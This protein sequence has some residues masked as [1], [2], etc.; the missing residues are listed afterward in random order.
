[1]IFNKEELN[2]LELY[3]LLADNKDP[4]K[5]D[6]VQIKAKKDENIVI[7]SQFSEEA[8]LIT[9]LEKKVDEEFT[10]ILPSP[11]LYSLIRTLSDNTILKIEKSGIFFNS[12]KYDFEKVDFELNDTDHFLML[13]EKENDNKK[14]IKQVDKAFLLKPYIGKNEL[15]VIHLNNNY[16]ISALSEGTVI[17]AMKTLENKNINFYFPKIIIDIAKLANIKEIEFDLFEELGIYYFKINKTTI[18]MVNKENSLPDIFSDDIKKIYEHNYNIIINKN[19]LL[20][21]L[22]R[23][24]I[25]AMNNIDSR[26]LCAFKDSKMYI[27]SKDNDYA[28]EIIN[29][30]IDKELE[31]YSGYLSAVILDNIINNITSENII[32]K[33]NPDKES[34]A[35]KLESESKD[36]FFIHCLFNY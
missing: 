34:I 33:I 28:C 20:E 19:E 17:A 29:A 26:I 21:S 12:N 8:T 6:K 10:L 14:V 9:K 5:N 3:S 27:E 11:K 22:K 4:R 15:A 16:F 23:I 18:F 25:I 31:N 24:K 1:M 36:T 2:F 32:L 30:K 7:F 13:S 35:I